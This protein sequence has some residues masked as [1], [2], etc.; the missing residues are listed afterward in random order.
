L[1]DAWR[2]RENFIG[3]RAADA[4]R[5][6]SSGRAGGLPWLRAGGRLW[7]TALRFERQIV[8]IGALAVIGAGV[9]VYL[10]S[11]GPGESP[12]RTE[13][14][15]PAD[16]RASRA[17][18]PTSAPETPREARPTTGLTPQGRAAARRPADRVAEVPAG[19]SEAAGQIEGTSQAAAAG[20]GTASETPHPSRWRA[21]GT[22]A[23]ET[24]RE[25]PQDDRARK[26]LEIPLRAASNRRSSD[27]PPPGDEAAAETP[28]SGDPVLDP[29]EQ[30]REQD[31]PQEQERES[32][33]VDQGNPDA[34]DPGEP[35]LAAVSLGTPVMMTCAKEPWVC[36]AFT[37]AANLPD[38]LP[39][40]SNGIEAI[41][42]PVANGP[43]MVWIRTDTG[44]LQVPT[45]NLTHPDQL[46]ALID[47]LVPAP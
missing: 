22:R 31:A 4:F 45:E 47:Q 8:G 44:V 2:G 36:N 5:I 40:V 19:E 30:S 46:A 9:L 13:S 21:P 18:Q 25:R 34:D 12:E 27:P 26:P 1:G 33:S 24:P 38:T 20:S 17:T 6:L 14:L 35:T 16:E 3:P 11:L 7:G 15:S 32:A 23:G 37:L 29:F 43:D 10:G 42:F 39:A 28:D 41:Q